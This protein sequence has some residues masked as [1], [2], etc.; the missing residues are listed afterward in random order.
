MIGAVAEVVM[1]QCHGN[2]LAS[3]DQR[4]GASRGQAA[5][6]ASS[7]CFEACSEGCSGANSGQASRKAACFSDAPA[8]MEQNSCPDKT[9]A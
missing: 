9:C 5:T 3:T 2:G 7:G 1:Q 8:A 4:R 6:L